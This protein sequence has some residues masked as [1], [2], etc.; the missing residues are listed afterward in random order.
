MLLG[1]FQALGFSG[2]F[3]TA[4]TLSGDIRT[5]NAFSGD[6]WTLGGS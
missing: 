3:R 1:D 5:V 6:I 4:K 2:D